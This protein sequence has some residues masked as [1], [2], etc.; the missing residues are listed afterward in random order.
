MDTYKSM[1]N[2]H[3]DLVLRPSS[4]APR[5]AIVDRD[6]W[7]GQSRARAIVYSEAMWGPASVTR[8]LPRSW[9]LTCRTTMILDGQG[10]TLIP[11]APRGRS[12]GDGN[13]QYTL[14]G[15]TRLA[16]VP[17]GEP[18]AKSAEL[19]TRWNID[20]AVLLLARADVDA[21]AAALNVLLKTNEALAACAARDVAAQVRSTDRVVQATRRQ[22]R[23]GTF[24]RRGGDRQPCR[25]S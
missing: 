23:L 5:V 11:A 18:P 14:G 13:A 24:A 1:R 19:V 8:P 22:G 9:N 21:V 6:L 10:W 12:F 16:A 25:R 17:I 3:S 2:D 4:K 15:T 20:D 7:G